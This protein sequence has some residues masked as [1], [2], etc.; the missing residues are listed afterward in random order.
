VAGRPSPT[1][2]VFSF[3]SLELIAP[4][5]VTLDTSFVGNAL[6]TG[7]PY[8]RPARNFLERLANAEATLVFNRLLEIELREIAFRI[9]LRERFPN[10]W[11]RR[12]HDGRS[13]RRARRLLARTMESWEEL[14]TAY[15][16]IRVEVQEVVDRLEE[17]MGRFGLASYDAVH[18]AT[19][20]FANA[21]IFVTTDVG[22][23]AVPPARLT[24]Y[25]NSARV[26]PARR[27]RW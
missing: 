25:T 14:L 10:D 2:G 19:A 18:A 26:S 8:H 3:E 16:Y 21:P 6:V 22:F 12:R 13:L 4:S 9:P 27:Q 20:E 7:E 5:E 23:A 15:D 17:L 11:K 1:R 24:I